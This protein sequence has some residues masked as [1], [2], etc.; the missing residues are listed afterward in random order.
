MIACLYHDCCFHG[1]QTNSSTVAHSQAK[2]GYFTAQ[3]FFRKEVVVIYY[4]NL[5]YKTMLHVSNVQG[6]YGESAMQ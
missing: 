6:I 4:E 3:A 2:E 5:M 1:V